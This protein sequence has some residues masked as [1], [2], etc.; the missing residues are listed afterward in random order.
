MSEIGII[1]RRL[2][3]LTLFAATFESQQMVAQQAEPLP[4]NSAEPTEGPQAATQSTTGG[5]GGQ[6]GGYKIAVGVEAVLV[7][8]V[9]RDLRGRAV[10]NLKRE[11]FQV[12]DQG[13]VQAISGFTVETR[14]G[15]ESAGSASATA[16][17]LTGGAGAAAAAPA[18]PVVPGG[19][20]PVGLPRCTVLLFDD[21]HLNEGDL[22]RAKAVG[23][24]LLSAP[25]GKREAVAVVSM[26]GSNSGLM[27]DG[28]K[29]QEAM[30]KL[31]MTSLYRKAQSEC[32]DVG[33]VEADRIINKHDGTALDIAMANYANC[34]NSV[35]LTKDIARS[36]VEGAARHVL[37]VGDQDARI[38]LSFI[39]GVVQRM[40]TL[41]GQRTVVLVSPGFLTMTPESL[42]FKSQI[43]DMAAQA[44]VTISALDARGVYTAEINADERGA[45]SL[46][47]LETGAA[48]DYHRET[49]ER[50]GNVLGELADGTGGTY[51]HGSN[52]LEGGLRSVMEGP[53]YLYVLEFSLDGVKHDGAYHTLSVR[54]NPPGLHLQ[55]RHGYF[56]PP[57]PKNKK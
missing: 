18:V 54:A 29:L 40:K 39:A 11:D 42:S 36:A 7:P 26:S 25:I 47:E 56:A 24:K 37:D 30:A 20:A 53:E 13:K 8:V 22:M 15:G 32:P 57:P 9:V 52:D 28:A 44:N 1:A 35:A 51:F 43:L 19:P 55:A 12:W 23:T 49:E 38:S 3:L 46:V 27:Q 16:P 31:H 14:A 2:A 10:G 5:A 6:N 48:Q 17:N 4:A 34:S 45:R 33:Y 41:P 50:A 21:M